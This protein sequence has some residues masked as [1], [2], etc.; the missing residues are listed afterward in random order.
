[1]GMKTLLTLIIGLL[2]PAAGL[3]ASTPLKVYILSGQSNMQGTA[4]VSAFDLT[5]EPEDE[6]Q[7][8]K[9]D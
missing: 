1:M 4:D 3:S 8:E 7:D 9:G 6:S 2:I 5:G